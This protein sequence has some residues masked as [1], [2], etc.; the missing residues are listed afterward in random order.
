M[1]AHPGRLNPDHLALVRAWYA[2]SLVQR[3]Q[4]GVAD[5]D[6]DAGRHGKTQRGVIGRR[7]KFESPVHM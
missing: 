1:S 7:E 5:L 6:A 2:A 4:V 3:A